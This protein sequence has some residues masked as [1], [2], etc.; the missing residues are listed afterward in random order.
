MW[1][2]NNNEYL[3]FS[4]RWSQTASNSPKHKEASTTFKNKDNVLNL[5]KQFL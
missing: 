2:W 5:K 3:K 1:T 4:N